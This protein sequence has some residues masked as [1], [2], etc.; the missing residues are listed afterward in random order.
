MNEAFDLIITIVNS[1]FSDEVMDAA[2]SAGARGGTILYARGSVGEEMKKFF[3]VTIDPE[4]EVVFILTAREKR[5]KMM[6][7]IAQ[8]AGIKTEG[9]GMTFSLPVEDVVGSFSSIADQ[10]CADDAE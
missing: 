10:Q 1:G 8:A 7:S 9:R 4:K 6:Q 2:R 3:G 5:T